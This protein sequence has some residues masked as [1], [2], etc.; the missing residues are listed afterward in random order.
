MKVFEK[1]KGEKLKYMDI[2]REAGID[3][4]YLGRILTSL[5]KK[6]K[7]KKV[8]LGVYKAVQ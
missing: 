5:V 6:G 8:E 3:P 2:A 1:H 4:K 7:L